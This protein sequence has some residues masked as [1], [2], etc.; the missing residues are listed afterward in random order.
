MV[1][2]GYRNL[3]KDPLG[4]MREYVSVPIEPAYDKDRP[5]A[6]QRFT[7]TRACAARMPAPARSRWGWGWRFCSN[8]R[9][10]A[11]WRSR[12]GTGWLQFDDVEITLRPRPRMTTTVKRVAPAFSPL[13]FQ[14]V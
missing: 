2:F 13:P 5:N 11:I 7:L 14:L 1:L 8:G 10:P 9:P 6:W 4:G 12:A 3:A